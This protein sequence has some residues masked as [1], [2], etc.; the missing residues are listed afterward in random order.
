MP[1]LKIKKLPSVNDME[2]NK[3][4]TLK[5][6]EAP[7]EDRDAANKKWVTDNFVAS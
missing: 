5:D 4:V 6:V 7:I 1:L 3:D 2:R